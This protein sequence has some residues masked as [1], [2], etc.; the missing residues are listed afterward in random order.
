MLKVS[1]ACGCNSIR[2]LLRCRRAGRGAV[3][4]HVK[5]QQRGEIP[6][7]NYSCCFVTVQE[8]KPALVTC[9]KIVSLAR[10]RQGQQKIIVRIRRAYHAWQRADILGEFLIGLDARGHCGFLQ[11]GSQLFELLGAD[12]EREISLLPSTINRG[13]IP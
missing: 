12:Q 6:G 2:F 1:R 3:A 8:Q 7:G 5:C 11:R 9:H 4:P 10:F 13:G